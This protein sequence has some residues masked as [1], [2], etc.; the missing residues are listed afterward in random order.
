[1]NDY[2]LSSLSYMISGAAPLSYNLAESLKAKLNGKT[3]IIQGY[4]RPPPRTSLSRPFDY[5]TQE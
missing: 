4:V 5:T 2:D 1:M 3:S